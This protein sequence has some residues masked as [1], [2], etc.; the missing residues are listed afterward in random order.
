MLAASAQH[1]QSPNRDNFFR[2]P[3]LS[4]R[5][6]ACAENNSCTHLMTEL[7]QDL[8]TDADLEDFVIWIKLDLSQCYFLQTMKSVNSTQ[9]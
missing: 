8:F 9:T 5:V 7:V 1:L 6:E 4:R 3:I 2:L